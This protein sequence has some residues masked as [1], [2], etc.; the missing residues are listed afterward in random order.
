MKL[1]ISPQKYHHRSI[2]T[3]ISAFLSI[4]QTMELAAVDYLPLHISP[5][6]KHCIFIDTV[7]KIF[8]ND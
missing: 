2:T 7:R 3:E 6:D 8:L 4:C 5:V 1:E